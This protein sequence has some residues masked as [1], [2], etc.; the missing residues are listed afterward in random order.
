MYLKSTEIVLHERKNTP[1]DLHKGTTN[2][3]V[4]LVGN[5]HKIFSRHDTFRALHNILVPTA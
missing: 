3:A 5:K 2:L 1:T 4:V